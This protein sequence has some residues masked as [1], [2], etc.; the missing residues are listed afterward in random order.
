MVIP[1]ESSMAHA[2]WGSIETMT[3]GKTRPTLYCRTNYNLVEH[4][5]RDVS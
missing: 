4:Q 1:P 5:N 3:I 2:A